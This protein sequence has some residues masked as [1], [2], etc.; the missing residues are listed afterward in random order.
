MKTPA[1]SVRH[2]F[3][4]F[5]LTLLLAGPGMAQSSA[6]Y[7]VRF[8][9]TWSSSTHPNAYPSGAH[10]SGPVGGTHD[11]SVH[12]WQ[13]AAIASSGIEIM[14]ET[15]SQGQLLAEVGAAIAAGSAGQ[16]IATG[17]IGS[18]GSVVTAF[19]VTDRFPLV[20]VVSMVAPSPDWFVGVDG[21]DL[22][23]N[24]FWVKQLT[25]PLLAWD[26]GSD[27]GANFTSPNFNT[28]PK[29]P[30]ALITGGPFFGTV[31][32]GTFTFTRTSN[33]QT[34]CTAKI[35][36]QGCAPQS[37]FSGQPSLSSSSPFTLQVTNTLNNKSGLFFYGTTGRANLPFSGGTLCVQPPLKRAIA[38]YSFGNPPP[39]D[40]S[41]AYSFDFNAYAQSGVNPQLTIGAVVRA[42]LWA[43]DRSHPDGTGVSMTD[44]IEFELCP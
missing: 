29:E 42:Q 25:V 34:Y 24:G 23:Q 10:F 44:A 33:A 16:T 1:F 18:P 6:T 28:Q 19:Q 11:G 5:T 2:A 38:L 35:N 12:F 30:I 41:G 3:S 22:R 20:T 17:S 43:R 32:L 15:G 9:A 4:I 13:P 14:A 8:D 40:C 31:P 36:S 21:L 26:A 37:G 39:D 27:S 7:E